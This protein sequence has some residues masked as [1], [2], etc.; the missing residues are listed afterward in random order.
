MSRK[1]FWELALAILVCE[2]AGAIGTVFT[3]S[4]IPMWYAGLVKP[5]FNPPS[6][7]FGP[8]WTLLYALM[9]IAVFI[10]AKRGTHN[11]KVRSALEIFCI[12]LFLNIIWSPIFFGLHSPS[13]A[14]ITIVFMW[15]AILGT[16]VSFAKVSTR[17][18]SLLIPYILWVSFATYLNYSIWIL[19]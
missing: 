11:L 12:Q 16:I 2:F 15:F 6:W 10:V 13:L 18:A 14:L 4:Q 7:I 3:A 19:N 9:G 8:V 17:A 5:S 1:S